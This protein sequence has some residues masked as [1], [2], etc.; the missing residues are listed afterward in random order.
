MKLGHV[1][2]AVA[3]GGGVAVVVAM[4]GVELGFAA[5][6]GILAAAVTFVAMAFSGFEQPRWPPAR[7]PDEVTRG[8]DVARLAWGFDLR[9]GT[10]GFAVRRRLRVLA[11]RRLADHGLTLGED[12]LPAVRRL[13]GDAAAH[14]L[15]A[16]RVT[17][18]DV[19]AT[20]D[21]LEALGAP[22]LEE[23]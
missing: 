4:L 22:E 6:W 19:S 1:V 16:Q 3:A 14:A 10:A 9:T 12:D 20:L 21:A 23:R 8:S 11:E 18:D 7:K 17:R 2:S 13:L 15:T 5:A